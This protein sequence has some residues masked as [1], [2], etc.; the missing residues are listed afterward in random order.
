MLASFLERRDGSMDKAIQYLE[1]V[2]RDAKEIKQLQLTAEYEL[3]HCYFLHCEWAKAVPAIEQYLR[4]RKRTK[5][6]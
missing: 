5:V 2:V 4:G 6:I 1:G 3:A